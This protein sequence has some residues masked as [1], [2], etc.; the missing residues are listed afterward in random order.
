MTDIERAARA[1]KRRVDTLDAPMRNRVRVLAYLAEQGIAPG[2]PRRR[3]T[4]RASSACRKSS[5]GSPPAETAQVEEERHR[6]ARDRAVLC[7]MDDPATGRRLRRG[8]RQND[9]GR[10]RRARPDHAEGRRAGLDRD[11]IAGRVRNEHGLGPIPTQACRPAGLILP[12]AVDLPRW[13]MFREGADRPAGR[14]QPARRP[15][16]AAFSPGEHVLDACAGAGGKTLALADIAR[17]RRAIGRDGPGVGQARRAQAA[18]GA[19]EHEAQ[20]EVKTGD[21]TKLDAGASGGV[22]RRAGRRPLHRQRHSPPAPGS[23]L[24]PDR[25]RCPRRKRADRSRLADR[26]ACRRSSPAD[27]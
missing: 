1:E 27:A 14:R 10:A 12:R 23:S 6:G 5:S 16:R 11:E 26:S 4:P 22:R 3:P 7:H 25:R 24:A 2:R 15:S 17:R 19:N 8:P 9:R 13:A 18:R 20:L 21:L